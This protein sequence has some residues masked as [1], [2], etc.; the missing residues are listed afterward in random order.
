MDYEHARVEFTK[1]V[2]ES[3]EKIHAA[4]DDDL[5]VQVVAAACIS[6]YCNACLQR[7]LSPEEFKVYLDIL[8]KDYIVNFERYNEKSR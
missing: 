2:N 4:L 8:L 6:V 7:G 5:R 1:Q 3:I